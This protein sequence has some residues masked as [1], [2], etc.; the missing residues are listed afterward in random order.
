MRLLTTDFIMQ[1]ARVYYPDTIMKYAE[2][3]EYVVESITA[4][5]FDQV[6]EEY[7]EIPIEF[8]Q[9]CLMVAMTLMEYGEL[10]PYTGMSVPINTFALPF[11]IKLL[12]KEYAMPG[13][14]QRIEEYNKRMKGE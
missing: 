3:A 12:L 10:N 14:E 8:S 4:K 2:P 5:T 13:I 1:N 9:A 7:G 6:E 11:T